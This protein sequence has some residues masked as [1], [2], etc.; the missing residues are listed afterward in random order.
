MK[1][2]IFIAATFLILFSGSCQKNK[3]TAI[4]GK[5]KLT[6][7]LIDIGDGK[8]QFKKTETQQIIEF[9]EDGNFTS[10][11]SLCQM[12]SENAK[13]GTGTFSTK[14]NKIIPGNCAEPNRDITFEINGQ[15]LILHLPCIE[16]CAQKYV[17]IN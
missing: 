12:P 17:R 5:W 1:K 7:E 2:A 8:G 3:P 14:E 4:I 13:N 9:F 10:T 16:P 15:E 6:E 11:T